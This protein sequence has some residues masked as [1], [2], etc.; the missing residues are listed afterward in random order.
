MEPQQPTEMSSEDEDACLQTL[1]TMAVV[2]SGESIPKHHS[3]IVDDVKDTVPV[4]LALKPSSQ[5]DATATKALSKQ[6]DVTA[7]KSPSSESEA[8][9]P[10]KAISQEK[11]LS[12]ELWVSLT[13]NEFDAKESVTTVTPATKSQASDFTATSYATAA[14]P[15]ASL[16]DTVQP[17]SVTSDDLQTPQPMPTSDTQVSMKKS[18]SVVIQTPLLVSSGNSLNKSWISATLDDIDARQPTAVSH[19][20]HPKTLRS[21]AE[22][23][24]IPVTTQSLP[25]ASNVKEFSTQ[26][27]LAS[28]TT[29][30]EFDACRTTTDASPSATHSLTAGEQET[31][32]SRPELTQSPGPLQ[33]SSAA[34]SH[35]SMTFDDLDA[36]PSIKQT[37]DT[38]RSKSSQLSEEQLHLTPAPSTAPSQASSYV[39]VAS[40]ADNDEPHHTTR[41]PSTCQQNTSCPQSYASEKPQA[42]ASKTDEVGKTRCAKS[43]ELT[44]IRPPST[45]T[46][47]ERPHITEATKLQDEKHVSFPTD[48]DD[49]QAET[50]INRRPT[51]FVWDSPRDNSPEVSRSDVGPMKTADLK[52]PCSQSD[53]ANKPQ[54]LTPDA[55]RS[56]L[57]PS[58]ALN[59]AAIDIPATSSPAAVVTEISPQE[60][61]DSSVKPDDGGVEQKSVNISTRVSEFLPTLPDHLVDD[62]NL[63][64]AQPVPSVQAIAD[65]SREIIVIDAPQVTFDVPEREYQEDKYP[66]VSP[67]S[68]SEPLSLEYDSTAKSNKDNGEVDKLEEQSAA[69]SVNVDDIDDKTLTLEPQRS[70]REIVYVS[71]VEEK[72]VKDTSSDTETGKKDVDVENKTPSIDH[73]PP[74]DDNRQHQQSIIDRF[75]AKPPSVSKTGVVLTLADFDNDDLMNQI[76]ISSIDEAEGRKIEVAPDI[77]ETSEETANNKPTSLSNKTA[78]SDGFRQQLPGSDTRSFRHP[79]GTNESKKKRKPTFVEEL[80]A[81]NKRRASFR[82]AKKETGT[83][84]EM[85]LGQVDQPEKEHLRTSTLLGALNRD[86]EC[87]VET[88]D[89]SHMASRPSSMMF[90]YIVS[91][92]AQYVDGRPQSKTSI[93]E[94]SQCKPLSLADVNSNERNV[95]DSLINLQAVAI[96]AESSDIQRSGAELLPSSVNAD[97]NKTPA[98]MLQPQATK[99]LPDSV[100][101]ADD[102]EPSVGHVIYVTLAQLDGDEN[103]VRKA[104]WPKTSVN[105]NAGNNQIHV[106][107]QVPA[108]LQSNSSDAAETR[109]PSLYHQKSPDQVLAFSL[110]SYDTYDDRRRSYPVRIRGSGGGVMSQRMKFSPGSQ[111]FDVEMH[112][113]HYNALA[114]PFDSSIQST[115]SIDDVLTH[116]SDYQ[117]SGNN[118]ILTESAKTGMTMSPVRKREAGADISKTNPVQVMLTGATE[119]GGVG[120]RNTS[121]EVDHVKESG[122]LHSYT[123]NFRS[124]TL[125]LPEESEVDER[126]NVI[127]EEKFRSMTWCDGA[128]TKS[129]LLAQLN[130]RNGKYKQ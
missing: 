42:S 89:Y 71:L 115:N 103:F 55:S 61:E 109:Q 110:N 48:F 73:H 120:V 24:G 46:E 31:S 98:Y 16:T 2:G 20:K 15:D 111:D 104:S 108:A 39:T 130:K 41:L 9:V 92:H 12:P 28:S 77:E 47:V 43:C 93:F 102:T 51:P 32:K 88:G 5:Q 99:P 112:D 74:I 106:S 38:K 124:M 29:L 107:S 121:A 35:V 19:T 95:A 114:K 50:A 45:W 96:P 113:K 122:M 67:E 100:P 23:N 85:P 63:P 54:T 11:K 80:L 76:G 36:P 26:K 53:V 3:V 58:I 57:P 59:A 116:Q 21:S 79:S 117:A 87:D 6:D 90:R 37:L 75:T 127:D 118:N 105:Q 83:P 97:N 70:L 82:P 86:T 64:D 125:T 10:P 4:Q 78:A 129:T 126:R 65:D 56:S 123:G 60:A 14:M 27:H 66:D 68:L 81:E 84:E 17:G 52:R 33:G 128:R 69:L 62:E 22:S 7:T 94:T 40:T 13:L 1:S 44:T 119:T 101:A 72:Q 8:I 30:E 18:P 34:K 49:D 91:P 25:S